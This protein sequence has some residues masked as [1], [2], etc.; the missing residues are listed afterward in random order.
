MNIIH[1]TSHLNAGGITSYVLAVSKKQIAAGH[2]VTVVADHGQMEPKLAEI[3]IK[4][5]HASLHTSAEFSLR[6]HKASDMIAKHFKNKAIDMIHAHTRVSHVVA[7]RLS[8]R[9][10]IPYVTTWHGFYRMNVGRHLWPCL[11][12]ATIAISE[13]VF[14]HLL[15]DFGVKK[16]HVHL[17]PNGVDIEQF[18][19]S[20]EPSVLKAMRQQFRIPED[21]PIV[22]TVS[23]L[24]ATKGVNRLIR[25]FPRI[26][27][28]VPN[29]HILIVGEGEVKESL[30]RLADE[31]GVG[32]A[33]HFTG[34]LSEPQRALPL[35]DVFVFLPGEDEGFGL[36]LLE[37]MA[38]SRAIVAVRQGA[39]A[40]WV[41]GKVEAVQ[42]VSPNDDELADATVAL[43][44]NPKLAQLLGTKAC[45]VVKE[46]FSLETTANS[47]ELLYREVIKNQQT[48]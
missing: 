4:Y 40:S 1:I 14:K 43:I 31:C 11:G 21:A 26:L 32:E 15:H 7:D 25:S 5:V 33:V 27:K 35:M 28:T 10:K 42:T 46:R 19:E 29:A 30:I 37:A 8:K 13:P 38:S 47:I 44:Q 24:V 6:I 41:L 45:S 22:G 9:L 18:S 34:A 17:I 39:G 36:T 3:G 48:L 16:Y 2:H 12:H 20:V 23:R